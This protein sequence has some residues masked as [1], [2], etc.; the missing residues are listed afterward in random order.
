[1]LG[2]LALA[3]LIGGTA[4]VAALISGHSLL[5][6]LAIYSLSGV[7]GALFIVSAMLLSAAIQKSS[8]I[9]DQQP[10]ATA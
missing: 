10:D 6:A 7:L 5:M 1:M 3:I 2:I 4:A 8:A 9:P